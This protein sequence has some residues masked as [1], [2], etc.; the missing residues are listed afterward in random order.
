MT[1]KKVT[2]TAAAKEVK[3]VAKKA[4]ETV[5]TTAK[6]VK[7]AAKKAAETVD[8]TTKEKV[9]PEAKKVVEKVKKATVK[10]EIKQKIVVEY[11]GNQVDTKDLVA[12]VKKQW[13]KGKNKVSDIKSM[14]LY[15]KPEDSA[16]YYVI[17]EESAGKVEF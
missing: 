9:V 17:N 11:Q 15:V 12:A 4:A 8:T 13:A 6:E 7:E 1:T 14:D 16:V 5:E 2:K 3:E 10:K